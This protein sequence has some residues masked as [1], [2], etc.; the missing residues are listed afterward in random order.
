MI[1][2][3]LKTNIMFN[4]CMSLY[5]LWCNFSSQLLF[6][7]LMYYTNW[8]ALRLSVT[9]WMSLSN[10]SLSNVSL[11]TSV[12]LDLFDT[13]IVNPKQSTHVEIV[14]LVIILIHLVNIPIIHSVNNDKSGSFLNTLILLD[15]AN[16]LAHVPILLQQYQ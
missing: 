7:V 5:W 6:S 15:C 11:S 3:A 2:T 10:V 12:T 8:T 4:L 1:W 9:I 13:N 16:A 14:T